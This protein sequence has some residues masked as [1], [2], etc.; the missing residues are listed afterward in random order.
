MIETT[1]ICTR[2]RRDSAHRFSDGFKPFRS[3]QGTCE[4]CRKR[5]VLRLVRFA[6]VRL[7]RWFAETRAGLAEGG[8][9]G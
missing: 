2:C 3:M 9:R 6:G 8:H 7:T 1:Y 5:V 4:H